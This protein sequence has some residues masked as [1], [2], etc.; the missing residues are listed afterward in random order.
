MKL[1]ALAACSTIVLVAIASP[2]AAQSD[3]SSAKAKQLVDQSITA[4]GGDRFLNMKNRVA[5]GRVYS[6]FHDQLS[7]LDVT[8]TYTEY[9]PDKPPKGIALREREI[10]G[11]K[12][13]YS[14]LFL[15]DQAWDVTY[16]GARPV[17][18]ESWQNYVRNT[19]NDILYILKVRHDEPGLIY[20]Y[21]GTDVYLSTHVEIVDI[22]DS[23]SR[24]VRVYF[25]HNSLLPIHETFTWL[26]PDTR[27]HN[28]ESFD[29]DKYRDAGDGIMWPLVIERARNGYKTY[30]MFATKVEVNQPVPPKV[31][32][33]PP[34]ARVLKKVN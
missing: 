22:T 4:L 34:G 17:P 33:L 20:D 27:A 23:Q 13:D 1:R 29:Y 24:T 15:S 8:T 18:D 19:E 26:D 10:L 25:D 28:D 9:L 5:R 30:Q 7:G 16:R 11:K 31:F 32:D 12:Q 21:V 14:Y 6:F 2:L 3:A